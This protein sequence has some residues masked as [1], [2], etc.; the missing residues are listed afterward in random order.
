MTRLRR[1]ALTI[2]R[3]VAPPQRPSWTLIVVRA[4]LETDGQRIRVLGTNSAGQD[5][6]VVVATPDEAARIVASWLSDL[7]ADVRPAPVPED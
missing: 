3:M 7:T 2:V 1:Y 6:A 4:W 5:A